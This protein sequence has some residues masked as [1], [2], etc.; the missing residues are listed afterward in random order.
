MKRTEDEIVDEIRRR[1]A[2]H[3][4]TFDYDPRRITQDHQRQERESNA[5]VVERPPRKPLIERKRSMA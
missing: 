3:A 2:A 1:R 5:S 4:E